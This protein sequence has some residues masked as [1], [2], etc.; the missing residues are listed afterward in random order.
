MSYKQIMKSGNCRALM[1]S[2]LEAHEHQT[3]HSSRHATKHSNTKSHS[4]KQRTTSTKK[5]RSH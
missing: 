5:H 3:Q 2:D 4:A 1:M